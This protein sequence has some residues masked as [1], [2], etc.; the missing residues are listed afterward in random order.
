MNTN[1][2]LESLL[3]ALPTENAYQKKK[4]KMGEKHTSNKRNLPLLGS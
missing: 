4:K 3:G 1:T 2:S